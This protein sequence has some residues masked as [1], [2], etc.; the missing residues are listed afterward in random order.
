MPSPDP[1]KSCAAAQANPDCG[2]FHSFCLGC[3]DRAVALSPQCFE[4]S[5]SGT[6]TASYSAKLQAV[7]GASND[8]KAAHQRVKAEAAR[9]AALKQALA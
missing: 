6:M 1:C 2:M 5:T 4:A 7:Y 9:I 3:T 8:L